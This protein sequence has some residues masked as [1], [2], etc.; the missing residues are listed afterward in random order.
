MLTTNQKSELERAIASYLRNNG[1]KESYATF[2]SETSTTGDENK[3]YSAFKNLIRLSKFGRFWVFGVKFSTKNRFFERTVRRS[4][5]TKMGFGGQTTK[6]V[7][8][9][10]V[11][12]GRIPKR[13]ERGLG[14]RRPRQTQGPQ[15]MATASTTEA[16][17]RRAQVA[18]H[19][20]QASPQLRY[21]SHG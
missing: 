6:K 15:P 1:Y 8:G 5:I 14:A 3:K 9:F 18:H 16:H 4:F 21:V 2:T 13:G 10:T 12:S 11:A 20:S 7:D 19:R 17:L